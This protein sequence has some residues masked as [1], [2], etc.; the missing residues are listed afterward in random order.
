[1]DENRLRG[2]LGL[3]VRAGTATFG[4]D[5]CLK[6][7]R[8]GTCRLLLVDAAASPATL[9][10]YLDACRSHGTELRIVPENLIG[11]A[12]GHS[13]VAV[14]LAQSGLTEQIIAL[15]GLKSAGELMENQEENLCGGAD[16]E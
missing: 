8:G 12:T 4:M 16:F 2:L 5:G 10:K 3:S 6:S 13:G 11:D 1:M 15:P 9:N 14:A 7:V